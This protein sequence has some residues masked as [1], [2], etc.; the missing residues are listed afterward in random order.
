MTPESHLI[1]SFNIFSNIV[2]KISSSYS[3]DIPQLTHYQSHGIAKY[4]TLSI[5][6]KAKLLEERTN[7]GFSVAF[8][9]SMRAVTIK[10]IIKNDTFQMC[11]QAC[12]K[13]HTPYTYT[14]CRDGHRVPNYSTVY[15]TLSNIQVSVFT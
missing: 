3:P 14:V 6:N 13:T 2:K 4:I 15:L 1:L 10:C 7:F 11:T 12:T 9:F 5:D 8:S